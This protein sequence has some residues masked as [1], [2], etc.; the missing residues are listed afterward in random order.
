MLFNQMIKRLSIDI[1][2]FFALMFGAI[3]IYSQLIP[4]ITAALSLNYIN[5]QSLSYTIYSILLLFFPI[6]LLWNTNKFDKSKLLRGICYAFAI[7][8]LVGTACDLISYKGFMGYK[9]SEGDMIFINIMWNMPNLFGAIFSIMIAALYF[10]LGKWIRRRRKI[11]YIIYL[12]IFVLS[13][14]MPFLYTFLASGFLPRATW[15]QKAAFIIPEQ[16]MI[17][18]ALSICASSRTLWKQH[19]W[20]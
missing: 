8:I 16:F 12:I 9:F 20:N 17:L 11:T 13:A 18:V 7:S 10:M 6:A 4:F 14:A 2:E 19:V 15:I 1:F 5:G 3:F